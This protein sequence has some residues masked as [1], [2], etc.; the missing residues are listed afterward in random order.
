MT[1]RDPMT[2]GKPEINCGKLFWTTECLRGTYLG[3]ALSTFFRGFSFYGRP[4]SISLAFF[5]GVFFSRASAFCPTHCSHF[6]FGYI[7]YVFK[8]PCRPFSSPCFILGYSF[9]PK[10]VMSN[11]FEFIHTNYVTSYIDCHELQIIAADRRY[12]NVSIP[13]STITI[14]MNRARRDTVKG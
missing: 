1:G 6:V 3:Q 14:G 2:R 5:G 4:T 11:G 7:G 8:L 12:C 9:V 13:V 10:S